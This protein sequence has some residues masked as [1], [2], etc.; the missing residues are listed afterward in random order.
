[1][2]VIGSDIDRKSMR[3]AECVRCTWYLPRYVAVFGTV[4]GG[5]FQLPLPSSL[6][7]VLCN[8]HLLPNYVTTS[9]KG[10]CDLETISNPYS[11]ESFGWDCLEV[12]TG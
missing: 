6:V 8:H 9:G 4:S 10:F 12:S 1:M 7:E 2:Q 5:V 11:L 3:N